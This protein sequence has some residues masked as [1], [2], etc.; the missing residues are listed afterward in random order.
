MLKLILFKIKYQFIYLFKH[1]NWQ[2]GVINKRII[3]VFENKINLN[4][5]LLINKPNKNY[6][7]ADPFGISYGN[8]KIIFFEKFDYRTSKGIISILY[9]F[10][11]L[12]KSLDYNKVKEII[13]NEFHISYPFILE[14][15]NNF[16]C[17][18]ETHQSNNIELYKCINFP[19]EWI[20][21]KILIRNKSVLDPTLIYYNKKWWIFCSGNELPNS[22]LYIFYSDNLYGPWKEHVNNPVKLDSRSSR[23]AGTPFLYKGKI[24]RPSQD[25]SSEYGKRII[26]NRIDILNTNSFYETSIKVLSIG[27]KWK[28][29][30]TISLFDNFTLCDVK[31]YTFNFN[32]FKN[33]LKNLIFSFINKIKFSLKLLIKF[34]KK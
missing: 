10:N 21:E 18:P 1:E 9:N 8:D 15:K 7:Y 16:Y 3:K 32:F 27:G 4:E 17:I 30:H 23:P 12:N 14:Y 22:S 2:L 33:N 24:I 11:Y 6:Y 13:K 29:L 5:I 20:R 26:F 25:C 31:N 34:R 28:G 19:L